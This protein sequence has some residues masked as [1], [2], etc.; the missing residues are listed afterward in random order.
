MLGV[1]KRNFTNRSKETIMPLY[2]FCKTS[3]RVSCTNLEPALSE[4]HWVNWESSTSSN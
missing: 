2:K 4:G 3:F 1:I